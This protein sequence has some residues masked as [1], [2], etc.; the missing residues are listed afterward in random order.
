MLAFGLF[1]EL[2]REHDMLYELG[3][4]NHVR[5]RRSLS[6]LTVGRKRVDRRKDTSLAE[7]HRYGTRIQG[8]PTIS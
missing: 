8:H 3:D 4:M 5:E 2:A 6:G 7:Y 1:E